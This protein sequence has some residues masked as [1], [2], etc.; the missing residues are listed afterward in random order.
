MPG[1]KERWIPTYL[2]LLLSGLYPK[3]SITVVKSLEILNEMTSH[4]EEETVSGGVSGDRQRG[5]ITIPRTLSVGTTVDQLLVEH[6]LG[7]DAREPSTRTISSP[8]ARY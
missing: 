8:Q 7:E 3:S 2:Y 4:A 1:S 5:E 6:S